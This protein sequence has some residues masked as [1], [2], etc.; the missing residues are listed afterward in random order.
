MHV[1]FRVALLTEETR[2]QC[3]LKEH[4]PTR[5]CGPRPKVKL[6]GP[7]VEARKLKHRYPHAFKV[8]LGDPSTNHPK[9][10]PCSN[11]L[12]FTRNP[13]DAR[14]LVNVRSKSNMTFLDGT[15]LRGSKRWDLGFEGC[16]AGGHRIVG[17]NPWSSV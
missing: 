16:R 10:N 12:G 17:F 9:S 4:R 11:F 7:K 5:G 14:A 15:G 8:K 6:L 2:L 1:G 3:H 13:L